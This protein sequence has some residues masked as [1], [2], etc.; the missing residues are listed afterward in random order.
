MQ[1]NHD[2][3]EVVLE[4]W[5]KLWSSDIKSRLLVRYPQCFDIIILINK[6][7]R[8]HVGS[9]NVWNLHVYFNL[10]SILAKMIYIFKQIEFF[11]GSYLL[12]RGC[13]ACLYFLCWLCVF[14]ITWLLILTIV[15]IIWWDLLS[16][17]SYMNNDRRD[18]NST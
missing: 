8:L 1:F 18:G 14:K 16:L 10:K 7:Y 5:L 12:I 6:I 17:R 4:V 15:V 9:E 2:L 13:I 3:S 11:L